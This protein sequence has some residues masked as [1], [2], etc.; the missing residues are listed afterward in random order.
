MESLGVGHRARQTLLALSQASFLPD[1]IPMGCLGSLNTTRDLPA[2]GR[3]TREVPNPKFTTSF[4]LKD[5]RAHLPPFAS[6]PFHQNPTIYHRKVTKGLFEP[7]GG[8]KVLP[9]IQ[10]DERSQPENSAE[11]TILKFRIGI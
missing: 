2:K 3:S 7:L 5:F 9:K 6:L 1:Y 10:F 8:L 4:A 11:F